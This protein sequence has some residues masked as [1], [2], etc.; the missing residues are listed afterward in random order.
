MK[1]ELVQGNLKGGMG[2]RRLK[3]GKKMKD[4][5]EGGDWFL[6]RKQGGDIVW[7]VLILKP[8]PLRFS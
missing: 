8:A 3:Q 5:G 7:K 1:D 4:R 6:W 2:E